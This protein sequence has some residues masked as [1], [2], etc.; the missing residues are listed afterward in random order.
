MCITFIYSNPSDNNFKFILINNRDEFYNRK[1]LKAELKLENHMKTIYGTD[2][3]EEKANEIGTWLAVSENSD[4]IRIGNLLNVT[5][6][7]GLFLFVN[8]S[9][10]PQNKLIS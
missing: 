8:F 7:D 1:T 9:I 3:D 2:V 6:S 4:R 10:F 5:G